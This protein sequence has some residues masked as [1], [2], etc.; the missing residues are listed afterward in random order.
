MVKIIFSE[1]DGINKIILCD[2]ILRYGGNYLTSEMLDIV[3]LCE[4]IEGSMVGKIIVFPFHLYI[5]D[6]PNHRLKHFLSGISDHNFVLKGHRTKE[7]SVKYIT[8]KC[9]N[10]FVG[11]NLLDAIRSFKQKLNISGRKGLVA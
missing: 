1:G 11:L 5:V 6:A 4:I 3:L 9:K 2:L 8:S 7:L 10:Q